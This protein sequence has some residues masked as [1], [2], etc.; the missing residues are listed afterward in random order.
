MRAF[1]SGTKTYYFEI[2]QRHIYGGNDPLDL[3]HEGH[4][5]L[6]PHGW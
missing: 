3:I 1:S 6:M 4:V 2:H 5:P